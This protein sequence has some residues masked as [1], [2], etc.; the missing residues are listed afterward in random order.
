MLAAQLT[1][2]RHIEVFERPS[3]EVQAGEVL[4]RV[5][6]VGICPGD[7]R[8]FEE[9][10]SAGHELAEPLTLGHEFSGTVERVG[11]GVTDV[12][13][14]TR[15]AVE[16]SW[17][18]GRCALC[19]RGLTNLCQD[20]RFPTVPPD[21]GAMAEFIAVPANALAPLPDSLSTTRGA[22]L[23]PLS[24]AVH[25]IRRGEMSAD[26]PVAILGAG[27]IG[28]SI[29]QALRAYG[30]PNVHAVE[31]RPE[32]RELAEKLGAVAGVSA[33]GELAGLGLEQIA[34]YEASGDPQAMAEALEIVEPG[35]RI[36]V[37]GIPKASAISLDAA[38]C[39]RKEITTFFVRRSRDA[40]HEAARLVDEGLVDLDCLP[41]QEFPLP[42]TQ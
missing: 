10:G 24:I 34:V 22:L 16:P 6:A 41:V 33:A 32:R 36:I 14:G 13:P 3:P 25:A 37:V 23:E 4:L 27:A 38:A 40:L 21:H 39:R 17:H 7:V 31:P 28:L 18:C 2:A 19:A 20:I 42:D 12:S 15:V 30:L 1:R 8:I 29:L 9:G 35:G 5:E 26:E 11:A